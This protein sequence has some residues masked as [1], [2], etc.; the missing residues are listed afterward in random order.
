MEDNFADEQILRRAFNHHGHAYELEVIRDGVSARRFMDQ[1]Q[2]RPALIIVDL[3]LP[4]IDGGTLLRA[5][6]NHPVLCE[7]PTAV[8]TASAS[9]SEYREIIAHGVSLYR[10]KPMNWEETLILA[11]ELLEI[12]EEVHA[13]G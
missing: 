9:P 7:A 3:H 13:A 10:T 12:C 2:I 1:A 11:H 8:L 4:D 6:R 5:L